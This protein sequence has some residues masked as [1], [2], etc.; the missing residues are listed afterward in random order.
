MYDLIL[1]M[2]KANDDYENELGFNKSDIE[3][4]MNKYNFKKEIVECNEIG[5]IILWNKKYIT[6]EEFANYMDVEYDKTEDK[7]WLVI[8][9]FGDI[10]S[11]EYE[12]EIGIL[13]QD[14]DWW[15]GSDY[16]E[17]T[18][19][20]S[21]YWHRYT[22]DTLKDIIEYCIKKGIEIE[23]EDG[24]E[25]ELMTNENT[26]L[27][28]DKNGKQDIYFKYENEDE[29]ELS[30]L[31]D[32]DEL[33]D[34]KDALNYAI[35]DAQE[36]A[37]RDEIYEKIISE[38]EDSIGFFKREYV[39]KKD[40]NGV[41]KEVEKIYIRLDNIDFGKVEEF[42]QDEYNEYDFETEN[43]GNLVSILKEMEFFEF[44][45]PDYQYV[46]GDIDNDILNEYT[47]DKLN[48]N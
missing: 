26:Y 34:L 19:I 9:S 22:E 37:D 25:Y 8:D 4:F 13:G 43:Y 46:S 28:P 33:S 40:Y 32:N 23:D 2:I 20:D 17:N 36:T 14:D 12:T 24:E 47:T 6:N 27:K 3:N 16:Y 1:S 11:K 39:K 5:K 30:S 29:V 10:L 41:E 42:L 21:Y 31:L 15:H 7:F 18:D 44:R 48:W 38:F 45:T 35:C